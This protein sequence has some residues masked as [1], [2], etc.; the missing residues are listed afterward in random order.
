[1]YPTE[2]YKI[3]QGYADIATAFTKVTG[4]NKLMVFFKFTPRNWDR[5]E[6][7]GIDNNPDTNSL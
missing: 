6:G 5:P 4:I 1:M 3:H 2:A 7:E